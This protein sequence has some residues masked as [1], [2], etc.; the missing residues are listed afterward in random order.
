M[1]AAAG[2][3]SCFSRKPAD[4]SLRRGPHQEVLRNRAAFLGACGIDHRRLVCAQQCHGDT[5]AVV[6]AQESGRGA[7]EHADALADTDALITRERL[8]PIS[9]FT[10]DCL[11]VFLFDPQT[12]AIGL[13]HA[14]WRG[15][16]LN[17]APKTVCAMH[18]QFGTDVRLLQVGFGPSI[19][20]CCYAVSAE[21]MEIFPLSVQARADALYLDLVAENRRQLLALGVLPEQVQDSGLCT[22]CRWDEFFSYRREKE[23]CGRMIAVMMLR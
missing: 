6:T 18:A 9:V 20:A 22:C 10:A 19:R 4:M 12:P 15:T 1:L 3:T 5:I 11:P 13:C 8:V 7:L 2:L 23:S 21:F 16:R 17:I 14:G